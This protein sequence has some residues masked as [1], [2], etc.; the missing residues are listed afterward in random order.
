MRSPAQIFLPDDLKW[1]K[2]EAPL[3]KS[4][5]ERLLLMISGVAS[6]LKEPKA[7]EYMMHGV[8]R[9]LGVIKRSVENIYL[10]FP[11]DRD[12]F[13]NRDELYDIAINLH[14]FFINIF[15]LLD[16]LAWI[17]V[18]E[19]GKADEI[20]RR[21]VNLFND[22]I[23]AL[24][25][26]SFRNYLNL[27][28]MQRWYNGTVAKSK[29]SDAD[30]NGV[31]ILEDLL[32]KGVL[33]KDSSGNI[34]LKRKKSQAINRPIELSGINFDEIWNILQEDYGGYLVDY[35]DSLAHRIPPYLPRETLTP[36]Q[37]RQIALLQSRL[38][39]QYKLM[40]F[41][42][43][44]KLQDE[45]DLIGEPCPAFRH[46]VEES[47]AVVLHLQLLTDFKTVEEIIEKFCISF[48][49]PGRV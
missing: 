44:E 12:F 37:E 1:L 41:D 11:L 45:M 10:I 29:F 13:M 2:E 16:N 5:Y 19:N 20:K 32:N 38:N 40:N 3:L 24:A 42:A 8:G 35:R 34:Y 9:R 18:Y 23:K 25:P 47:K 30:S 7:K 33:A 49:I 14:A 48:G 36:D 28:H 26:E 39:D 15:G 17:I 43:T 31:T 27:G 6:L 21:E 4:K 46:A 22:K